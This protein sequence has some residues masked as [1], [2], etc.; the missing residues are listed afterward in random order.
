MFYEI[1]GDVIC[2]EEN[3]TFNLMPFNLMP[4]AEN[5]KKN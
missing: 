3:T 2:G 1:V 5:I 4:F